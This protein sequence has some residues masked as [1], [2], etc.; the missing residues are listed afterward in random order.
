M[1]NTTG[2]GSDTGDAE[3]LEINIALSEADIPKAVKLMESALKRDPNDVPKTLTLAKLLPQMARDEDAEQILRDLLVKKPDVPDAW[4]DLIRLLKKQDRIE[5][6]KALVDQA[7]ANVPKE[8]ADLTLGQCYEVLGDI[9]AAE[10]HF[11]Q[12]RAAKPDDLGMSRTLINF[13]ARVK[14]ADRAREELQK[15]A[16][17]QPKNDTDKEHIAWANRELAVLIAQSGRYSDFQAA[18]A[19]LKSAAPANGHRWR[20]KLPWPACY[21]IGPRRNPHPGHEDSGKDQERDDPS[22]GCPDSSWPASTK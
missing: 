1:A 20:T 14:S 21:P 11:S 6:A 12:A 10:Q 17:T 9:G 16:D 5:D 13:Y 22:H 7:K 4:L 3:L 2:S 15:L 8:H 18:M 19:R